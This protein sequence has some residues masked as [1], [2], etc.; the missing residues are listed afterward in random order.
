M[1]LLR[2]PHS[3]CSATLVHSYL[4]AQLQLISPDLA[5]LPEDV[6]GFGFWMWWPF[7]A[8]LFTFALTSALSGVPNTRYTGA[9][10]RSEREQPQ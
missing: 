1:P 7:I 9:K 2:S 10:V 6:I 8:L 4:D 3:C 5:G